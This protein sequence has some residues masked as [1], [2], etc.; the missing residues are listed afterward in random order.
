M[1]LPSGVLTAKPGLVKPQKLDLSPKPRR[2][3]WP[4]ARPDAEVRSSGISRESLKTTIDNIG[5]TPRLIFDSADSTSYVGSGQ[6]FNSIGTSADSFDLGNTSGA[7]SDDPTFVGIADAYDDGTY[8]SFD[9]GDNFQDEGGLETWMN[10]C[11]KSTAGVWTVCMLMLYE[12]GARQGLWSWNANGTGADRVGGSFIIETVSTTPTYAGKVQI[13]VGKSTGETD[14]FYQ[15]VDDGFLDTEPM[16]LASVCDNG[17]SSTSF[18]YK[19]GEY[20]T[21]DGGNDT[22]SASYNSHTANSVNP[23]CIGCLSRAGYGNYGHLTNGSKFYSGFFDDTAWTKAELDLIWA[24][25]G[26][27]LLASS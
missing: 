12:P 1:A 15:I 4:T 14:V 10:G 8:F 25:V 2:M 6:E 3:V 5:K 20:L 24:R 26:G 22:Y 27:W 11:H 19:N 21:V 17:G 9:G 16:M 18:F 7:S 13:W 23:M